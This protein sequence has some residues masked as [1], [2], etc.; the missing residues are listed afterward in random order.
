MDFTN[1]ED[2]CAA[3]LLI[4]D[5]LYCTLP[6]GGGPFLFC[7]VDAAVSLCERDYVN[8]KLRVPDIC[9]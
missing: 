9:S 3:F 2:R 7:L 4:R 6:G 5:P 1:S 8:G